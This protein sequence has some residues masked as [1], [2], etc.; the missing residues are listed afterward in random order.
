LQKELSIKIPNRVLS[1][2]VEQFTDQYGIDFERM[3]IFLMKIQS[4]SNRDSAKVKRMHFQAI[5]E[6]DS[7]IL[8]R[9]ANL[10]QTQ[11]DAFYP[12]FDEFKLKLHERCEKHHSTMLSNKEITKL[13]ENHNI[14]LYGALLNATF[15]RTNYNNLVKYE[16]GFF[17]HQELVNEISCCF[18]SA[19]KFVNFLEDAV[20]L[21]IESTLQK[22]VKIYPTMYLVYT[23]FLLRLQ[24]LMYRLMR[25]KVLLI[26]KTF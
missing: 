23:E 13:V 8:E 3:Y 21:N 10:F 4:N 5:K 15:E 6:A 24:L 2:L 17:R 7:V 25:S 19:T 9:I 22:K 18:L 12:N 26:V 11:S 14:P 1:D 20:R 16:G